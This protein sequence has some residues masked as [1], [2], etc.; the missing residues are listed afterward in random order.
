MPG[1]LEFMV[2]VFL[3]DW[4]EDGLLSTDSWTL[5]PSSPLLPPSDMTS[6]IVSCLQGVHSYFLWWGIE[7]KVEGFL[8]QA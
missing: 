7:Q 6:F 1:P 3:E 8:L 2:M 5:L 4:E